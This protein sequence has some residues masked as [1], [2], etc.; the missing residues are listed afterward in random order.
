MER[1]QELDLPSWHILH[2]PDLEEEI[3]AH[4]KTYS[5][6]LPVLP[7]HQE[8]RERNFFQLSFVRSGALQP[9]C[10]HLS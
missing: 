1:L 2:S 3:K 4:G 7:W 6:V 5:P 8:M 10:V 9:C